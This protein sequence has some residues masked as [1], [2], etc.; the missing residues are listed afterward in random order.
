[1]DHKYFKQVRRFLKFL[2][3]SSFFVSYCLF[4]HVGLIGPNAETALF[5]QKEGI[6]LG[7][8]CR[9]YTNLSIKEERE[10]CMNG[11]RRLFANIPIVILDQIFGKILK[12]LMNDQSNNI[13][14]KDIDRKS[15][16]EDQKRLENETVRIEGFLEEFGEQN[17]STVRSDLSTIEERKKELLALSKI[18]EETDEKIERLLHEI[19]GDVFVDYVY[20][21]DKET[22]EFN[23]LRRILMNSSLSFSGLLDS[24]FV[25]I[26]SGSFTMGSPREEKGR[27]PDE[28]QVE[29]T[30]SS[31]FEIMKTE[32]TQYQWFI[33]M[34]DNPSFFNKKEYCE[35]DYIDFPTKN[36]DVGL[37]PFHPVETVS[38]D[39]VREFIGELNKRD[40]LSGC[41][42]IE[43]GRPGCYRLPTEAEW[44]FA[45]RA[46]LKTAYSFGEGHVSLK[47]YAWYKDNSDRQTHAVGGRRPNDN[48]LFDTMGNVWEWVQNGHTEL[49]HRRSGFYPIIRGGGFL[50][51]AS[52]LRLANRSDGGSLGTKAV[53]IRLV[54]SLLQSEISIN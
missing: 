30:L 15:I 23:M 20:S 22:L 27:E 28:Y 2:L 11:P 46:G 12:Q 1:M 43:G 47:T 39:R 50:D 18:L 25:R 29:V 17:A 6:I 44:E 38:W 36:G 3:G 14:N 26:D 41:Y 13:Y 51:S 48:G 42:V 8:E 37:C 32:V 52:Q 16:L 4:A 40:N 9:K 53:G 54:K 19:L 35:D 10:N 45:A 34:G 24:D 5:Y 7:V 49:W 21:K 31:S 33:V